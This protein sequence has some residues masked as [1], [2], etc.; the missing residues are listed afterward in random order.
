MIKGRKY[1]IHFEDDIDINYIFHIN[2]YF[3]KKIINKKYEIIYNENGEQEKFIEKMKGFL[4]QSTKVPKNEIFITNI[5]EE[6]IAFDVIF[7]KQDIR[8]KIIELSKN[9][10]IKSIYEKIY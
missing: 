5:R 4:S 9:N 10:K 7:K 3:S 2:I 1:E 6:C 8:G